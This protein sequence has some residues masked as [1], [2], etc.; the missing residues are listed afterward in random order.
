M[1]STFCSHQ[2]NLALAFRQ[3]V[4]YKKGMAKTKTITIRLTEESYGRLR[5][6]ADRTKDPYAPAITA[7]A[8]RGIEL[9]LRELEKKKRP[10]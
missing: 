4:S 10:R 7:I 1:A 5:R 9:A 3:A 2:Y 8:E 6:A